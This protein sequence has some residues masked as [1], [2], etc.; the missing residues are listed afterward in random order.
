MRQQGQESVTKPDLVV[1]IL[2][3]PLS[4][5]GDTGINVVGQISS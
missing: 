3:Y 5:L 2:M 4:G 1:F